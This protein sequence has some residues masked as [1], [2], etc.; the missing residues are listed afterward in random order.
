MIAQTAFDD[1]TQSCESSTTD[2][3]NI[4]GV[5]LQIFLFGVLASITRAAVKDTVYQF[6]Q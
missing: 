6:H 4:F 5:E 2:K 3:E 1:F